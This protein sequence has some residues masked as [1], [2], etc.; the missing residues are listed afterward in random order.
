MAEAIPDD[1]RDGLPV[2]H[3][4]SNLRDG[5]EKLAESLLDLVA[6]AEKETEGSSHA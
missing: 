4:L 6:N 3:T 5:V 2:R 1:E